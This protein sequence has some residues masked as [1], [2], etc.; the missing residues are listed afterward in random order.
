MHTYPNAIV[1]LHNGV[2]DASASNGLQQHITLPC[3]LADHSVVDI[4]IGIL[5]Q[6]AQYVNCCPIPMVLV[7]T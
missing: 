6:S 4:H 7:I 5:S 2:L 1:V 3:V